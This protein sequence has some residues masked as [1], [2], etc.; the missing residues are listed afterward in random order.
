MEVR[1]FPSRVFRQ[2]GFVVKALNQLIRFHQ[3]IALSCSPFE[4]LTIISVE[5]MQGAE[6]LQSQNAQDGLL[7]S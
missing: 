1:Q 7:R 4:R 2:F 3:S 5:R 6:I